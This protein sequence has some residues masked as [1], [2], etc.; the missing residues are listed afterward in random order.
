[1]RYDAVRANGDPADAIQCRVVANPTIIS[2][3]YVPWI[4]DSHAWS[5]V[6]VHTYLS[7]KQL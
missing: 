5:D 6:N 7:P 1:L 2:N 4:G 3:H